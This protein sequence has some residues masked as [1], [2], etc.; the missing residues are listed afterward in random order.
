M[1]SVCNVQGHK[2]TSCATDSL[3]G[4]GNTMAAQHKEVAL[5]AKINALQQQVALQQRHLRAKAAKA[6]KVPLCAMRRKG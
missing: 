6:A 3:C 5:A 4:A 2:E 1:A